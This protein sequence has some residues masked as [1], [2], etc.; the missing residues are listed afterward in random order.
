MIQGHED[1]IY[2]NDYVQTNQ[3]RVDDLFD[4]CREQLPVVSIRGWNNR[5]YT[6]LGNASATCDC[7]GKVTLAELAVIN[8]RI[9]ANFTSTTIPA[10]DVIVGW[11]RSKVGL[12]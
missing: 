12:A 1:L 6:P 7:C 5:F 8:P 3:E 2:D 10:G 11:A 4:N 9:E